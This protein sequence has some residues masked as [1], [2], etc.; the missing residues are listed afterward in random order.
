MIGPSRTR[1]PLPGTRN[2][3]SRV[4]PEG[5]TRHAD[6]KED[7]QDDA[8]AAGRL[9]RRSTSSGTETGTARA[10]AHQAAGTRHPAR[11]TGDARSRRAGV[12]A[13]TERAHPAR[14]ARQSQNPG[15]ARR[16][17]HRRASPLALPYVMAADVFGEQ[18]ERRTTSP[19]CIDT[20]VAAVHPTDRGT[21]A[22]TH[23]GARRRSSPSAPRD[24]PSARAGRPRLRRAW[25]AALA[26]A[27]AR[28]TDPPSRAQALRRVVTQ[29]QADSCCAASDTNPS[30]PSDEAFSLP[31][32]AA[33]VASTFSTLASIMAPPASLDAWRTHVPLPVG[34][35]PKHVL[36]SVFLI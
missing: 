25:L 1:R 18:Q 22:Q 26:A 27:I 29:A 30:T 2:N 24:G 36:L 21:A 31:L 3:G 16:R 8:H 19:S 4:R 11:R 7:A 33:L 34:Q 6:Q 35:V 10:R 12:D 13:E 23:G 20:R 17:R 14:A 28:C 15:R 5:H 32:S 9:A